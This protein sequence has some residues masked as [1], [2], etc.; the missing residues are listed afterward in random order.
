MSL[1]MSR[2][3]FR[4]CIA[5]ARKGNRL[6]G[7]A[8]IT[9]TRYFALLSPKYSFPLL[10][11]NVDVGANISCM[12]VRCKSSK[13]KGEKRQQN[14]DE[15]SDEVRPAM[16]SIHPIDW[17]WHSL[18]SF[19]VEFRKTNWTISMI[20]AVL[21]K[22]KVCFDSKCHRCALMHSSER[23]WEYREGETTID[24]FHALSSVIIWDISFQQEDGGGLLCKQNSNQWP[25]GAKEERYGT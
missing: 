16:I 10:E 20:L 8:H 2:C 25:E 13:K 24:W 6:T 19:F 23:L 14:K 17:N 15:D 9:N 18:Y 5:L 7:T 1:L 12:S 11:R 4:P 3:P 21:W 22:T